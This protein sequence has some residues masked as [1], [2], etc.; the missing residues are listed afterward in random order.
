MQVA[1]KEG[2]I[3]GTYYV[4]HI[5]KIRDKN[6]GKVGDVKSLNYKFFNDDE[7]FPD[8]LSYINGK[9]ID[10]D[11]RIISHNDVKSYLFNDYSTIIY[12][13]NNTSQGKGV[14]VIKKS[15]FSI[16][17]ISSLGSGLFQ[18]YILQH[19]FFN[20]VQQSSVNLLRIFTTI[21]LAGQV[22]I[23]AIYL[24]T[25]NSNDTHVKAGD[26]I[27]IPVDIRTGLLSKFGYSP[28]FRKIHEHPISQFK[29]ANNYIPNFNKIKDKVISLHKMMPHNSIIGW[30]IILDTKD[31]VNVMEW[32]TNYPAIYFHEATQ[33][34]CFKQL[35]WE[36]F[37]RS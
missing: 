6:S 24:V 20:N 27:R 4:Q 13:L 21:D 33:G 8:V 22:S 36:R 15:E 29:F 16:N 31:N 14:N 19:D 35:N 11:N 37:A 9:F 1:F 28:D 26:T 34:P 2:W 18:K 30:D 5:D 17:L 32:N 10:L 25:A 3:P 12:K 7:A 23:N